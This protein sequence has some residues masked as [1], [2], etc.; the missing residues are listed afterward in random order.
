MTGNAIEIEGLT[1]TYAASGSQPPK[2]A[3][4][5]ID[6]DIPAG[7]IFGLLGPNGAGKSTLI[8]ILAGLVLKTSGK[9]SIWGFDQDVNPRQSRASIGVMPQELNIDPF[10]TPRAALEVQAGLYGVPKS[11]RVTD[12]VLK[13]IGLEDKADAYARNLSGG[14]RRRLL[15]GKALV[16]RPQVLVLDEPTAGV[17]IELRQMLWANI[18]RLNEE[19]GTTII[20]TTHYLEE[21]QEMCGEIAIINHGELIA[22]DSTSA[23]IGRMD[24][25]TL[26]IQPEDEVAAPPEMPAPVE[27]CLRPDGALRFTYR[28]SEI[29]TGAVIEAVRNAGISIRDIAT[30]EPN[31]EDVFVALTSHKG[32]A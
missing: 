28:R 1:K 20:L 23:L 21:A 16:H 12:R 25:K 7:S 10:F 4:K 3:L 8:N 18:R 29:G 22:R 17:D 6:L 14:M 2:Q 5:G 9:V 30:E 19:Q 31:L 32:A 11:Q 27:T 24:A 15:L 26:V 13:A